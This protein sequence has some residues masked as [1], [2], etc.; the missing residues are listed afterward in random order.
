MYPVTGI[1][2]LSG[3]P[4]L[5]AIILNGFTGEDFFRTMVRHFADVPAQHARLKRRALHRATT[6]PATSSH[7]VVGL[8]AAALLRIRVL[9]R[10]LPSAASAP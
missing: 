10:L 5:N 2:S 8:L 7:P 9:L 6:Q 1:N 4:D 3:T